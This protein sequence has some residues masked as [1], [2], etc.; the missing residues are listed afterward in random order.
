MADYVLVHG[1]KSNGIVWQKVVPLLEEQGHRV[2][3][4]SLPDPEGSSLSEHVSVVCKVLQDE[5]LDSVILVGHS[6]AAFVITGVADRMPERIRRLIYVD[7]YV[8]VPGKSLHDIFDDFGMT[9]EEYGIPQAPP[10]LEPLNFDEQRLREIPKTYILCTQ[11]EF[12]MVS[13]PT[14]ER[15]V[16]NA[17]RDNWDYFT[18]DSDHKCMESHPA[19]LTQILLLEK[20]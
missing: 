20:D 13:K 8:P 11:S 10:F 5:D 15:V 6:Y 4:P 1:G 2:Y 9:F 3:T 18:L 14:Y 7:S 19:E 12:S 16:E 17:Q